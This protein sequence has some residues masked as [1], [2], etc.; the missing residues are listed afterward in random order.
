MAACLR[1]SC[2][3][4]LKRNPSASA[5]SHPSSRRWTSLE[6]SSLQAG[7]GKATQLRPSMVKARPQMPKRC[8][9]F[10]AC[11]WLLRATFLRVTW[12]AVFAP[13]GAWG[14]NRF[15][16][17]NV[18]VVRL[19]K[20]LLRTQTLTQ[21]T[22]QERGLKFTRQSLFPPLRSG[23]VR[24]GRLVTKW[25]RHPS[26]KMTLKLQI[27]EQN[28]PNKNSK[29]KEELKQLTKVSKLRDTNHLTLL[30]PAR[31]LRLETL[32]MGCVCSSLLSRIPQIFSSLSSKP[33]LIWIL[34]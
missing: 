32:K 25:L 1:T 30:F 3:R 16:K 10:P 18:Q 24:E 23:S 22:Q 15:W 29:Y 13:W 7:R 34:S 14:S 21:G 6:R 5:S 9:T 19:R 20:E 12:P 2:P 27:W 17:V 26:N 28:L 31:W 4:L 8:L 33:K 11:L